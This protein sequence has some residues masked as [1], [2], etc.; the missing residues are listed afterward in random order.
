M[1]MATTTTKET[2]TQT[3]TNAGVCGATGTHVASETAK[4]AAPLENREAVSYKVQHTRAIW[5]NNP[6]LEYFLKRKESVLM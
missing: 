2:N 5:P 4:G 3:P 6:I 1:K